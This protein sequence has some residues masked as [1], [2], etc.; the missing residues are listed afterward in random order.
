M[1]APIDQPAS[2][3][4][5]IAQEACAAEGVTLDEVRERRRRWNGYSTSL[6]WMRTF[7]RVCAR[8]RDRSQPPSYPEIASLFCTS[9]STIIGAVRR[10]ERH[11]IAVEKLSVADG[12]V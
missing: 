2:S 3:V 5:R 12:R 6:T 4:V 8:I 9:H 7:D 1:I 11:G 10:A